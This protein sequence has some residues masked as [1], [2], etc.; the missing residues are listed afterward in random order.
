MAVGLSVCCSVGCS[1]G[2]SVGSGVTVGG[3]AVVGINVALAVG[4]GP[5]GI[6]VRVFV[7]V[8]WS[9]K[10]DTGVGVRGCRSGSCTLVLVGGKSN[11]KIETEVCLGRGV[12][13]GLN[14]VV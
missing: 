9:V 4:N 5:V 6:G 2:T 13:K 3:T 12:K 7:L 8:R 1:V 10:V 11:E 14:V